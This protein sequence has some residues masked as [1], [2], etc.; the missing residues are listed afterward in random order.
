MGT[1]SIRRMAAG[2]ALAGAVAVGG[3]TVAAINP[4]G[5]AGAQDGSTTTTTVA[6]PAAKGAAPKGARKVV[7]D[8]LASLVADGTLTQP[9]ADAVAARLQETAK[10]ARAEHKARRTER[11]QEMLKVAADAIGISTDD[12]KAQ[13]KDGTTLKQV[14]EANDV[15][16]Q[17][18]IDALVK[19]ANERI[20]AAVQPG[21]L[22]SARADAAKQR[23]ADRIERV[24]NDGFRRRGN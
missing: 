18:V 19:A 22:D 8:A 20:D 2:A 7:Q 3:L 24:V 10:A 14:A 16:P 17:K 13:L 4:L 5:V 6:P 11:R 12:L 15:D 21:K 1:K 9:Q 23:V